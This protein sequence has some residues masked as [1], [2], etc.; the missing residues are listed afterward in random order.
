M[1]DIVDILATGPTSAARRFEQALADPAALGLP[2]YAEGNPE[3]YLFPATY[4]IGPKDKPADMLPAWSTAGARRP[5]RP[6]SR[7]RPRSWATPRPS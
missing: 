4:D 6:G 1:V 5:T 2:D 7:P 3:G